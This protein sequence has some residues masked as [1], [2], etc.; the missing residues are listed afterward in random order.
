MDFTKNFGISLSMGFPHPPRYPESYEVNAP[1]VKKVPCTVCVFFVIDT[2]KSLEHLVKWNGH[3][4]SH[5]V[6]NSGGIVK[7]V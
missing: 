2:E 3:I 5:E 7:L 6:Y 4:F 1:F